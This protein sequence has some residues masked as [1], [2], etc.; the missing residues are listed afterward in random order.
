MVDIAR[1]NYACGFLSPGP[2]KS[3][4]QRAFVTTI[5]INSD[6]YYITNDCYEWIIVSGL[7]DEILPF[8]QDDWRMVV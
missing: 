8:G 2:A 1:N 7:I 6:N 3:L 5:Y 4:G